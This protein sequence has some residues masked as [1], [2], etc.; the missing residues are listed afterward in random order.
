MIRTS[1]IVAA[2]CLLPALAAAQEDD[3]AASASGGGTISELVS[4]G[5]EIKTATQNGDR[6]I[7]FLQK[8]RSAYACEF[9]ALAKTRC[10]PIK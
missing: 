1:L 4:R 6:T 2:L 5:Y 8:D 9:V 10:G 3:V 7:V